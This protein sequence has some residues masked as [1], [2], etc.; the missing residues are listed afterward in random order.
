MAPTPSPSYM[1]P[2]LPDF[3]LDSTAKT[4]FIAIIVLTLIAIGINTL[5]VT[6]QSWPA[7][8]LNFAADALIIVL[9]ILYLWRGA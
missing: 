9:C 1:A 6:L 4:V 2:L 7:I 3:K 5:G 8:Y